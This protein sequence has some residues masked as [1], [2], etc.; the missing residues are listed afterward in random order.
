LEPAKIA[1]VI[2]KGSGRSFAS[3]V[4]LANILEGRFDQGYPLDQAY[5]DMVQAGIISARNQIP[6]PMVHTALGTYQTA[7]GLGL[8]KEDKG[9]MI[10]VFERLLDIKFRSKTAR[11]NSSKQ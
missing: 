7:L 4:F 10:K 9:A 5:K 1:Q 11:A 8:G 3:D 6:L 2:N